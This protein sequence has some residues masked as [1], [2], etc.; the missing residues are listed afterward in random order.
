MNDTLYNIVSVRRIANNAFTIRVISGVFS[1]D[2]V[3][4]LH[5]GMISV[6]KSKSLYVVNGHWHAII[7]DIVTLFE[8]GVIKT[9][10]DDNITREF[11]P[12]R[13]DER[14]S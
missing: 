10:A 2:L 4:R 11:R 1:V 13:S 6:D 12:L 3:A 8:N 9:D 5:N 7:N 14:R